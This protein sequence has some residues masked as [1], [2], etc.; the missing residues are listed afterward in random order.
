MLIEEDLDRRLKLKPDVSPIMG[1]LRWPSR[2]QFPN[3]NESWTYMVEG[4][5]EGFAVFVGHVCNGRAHPFEVW[6]NGSE[7]P[8]TLGAVAK[9]L[10]ADMRNQDRAWLNMKLAALAKTENDKS[11]PMQLGDRQ[12]VACSASSALAQVVQF[13]LRQLGIDDIPAG[14]EATPLM[15]QLMSPREPKGA[16]MSWTL[17]VANPA[18]GDDFVLFLKEAQLEDGSTRPYSLWLSGKYPREL[19]GLCKLLSIDMRVIDPA[20]VGMKLRKLLNYEEPMGS[21]WAKVPG[22]E[23]SHNYPS[24]VAYLA[25]VILH[26]FERHGLLDA[27]GEP[28]KPMGVLVRETARSKASGQVMAGSP[29]PSCHQLTLVRRDGF[30]VCA[31]P[32]CSYEGNCG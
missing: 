25:R 14:E 16:T 8:R 11:F 15:D 17:D 30:S 6:V 2:P 23:K 20:W 13:R 19:D 22:E 32:D 24:T 5:R 28:L 1:S 21:F 26:R 10:S 12:V 31:S 7:Q 18:A 9:T 27:H 3:G 29:C 4:A